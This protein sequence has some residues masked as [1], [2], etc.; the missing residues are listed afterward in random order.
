MEERVA[1][2][3]DDDERVFREAFQVFDKDN[4]GKITAEELR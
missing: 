2:R 3:M 1:I 4:S